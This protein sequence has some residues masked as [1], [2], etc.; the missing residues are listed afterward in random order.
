MN[1]LSP[2]MLKSLLPQMKQAVQDL[3]TAPDVPAAVR[4]SA[5]ALVDAIDQWVNP[6]V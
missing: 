3:E 1:L 5:K 6:H 2:L 4:A